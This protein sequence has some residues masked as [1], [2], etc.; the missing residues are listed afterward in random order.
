MAS[1]QSAKSTNKRSKTSQQQP[2]TKAAVTDEE[3][4]KK[5][6]IK[7]AKEL[8]K[9]EAEKKRNAEIAARIA[10]ANTRISSQIL[11]IQCDDA[12]QSK[13]QTPPQATKN[14]THQLQQND[15]IH[16]PTEL[17]HQKDN[18][19]HPLSLP[20][21]RKQSLSTAEKSSTSN[22]KQPA[23][24]KQK[25]PLAAKSSTRPSQLPQ[26]A[27]PA[28]QSELDHQEDT[29]H[30]LSLPAFRKQSPSTAEKSSTSNKKQPA[31]RKQK[32]PLAAKSS[33]HPSQLP[34][35]ASPACQSELDHQEDTIHPLSLP[36]FRNQTLSKPLPS[37]ASKTARRA[38]HRQKDDAKKTCIGDSSITS[39]VVSDD[40]EID[41]GVITISC[42]NED[43]KALLLENKSL[44]DKL[45]KLQRRL[46][47]AG[48]FINMILL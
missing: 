17:E 6:A 47:I 35:N 42:D 38:P 21:F 14:S 46:D 22:K 36:A 31:N 8:E 4:A 13:Q 3:K 16:Q 30:P 11:Q 24:R 39:L 2:S 37:T 29:I 48:K 33:T 23:N 5:E 44:R 18:S 45:K 28:C 1:N 20:A 19:I 15:S 9:V 7:K 25:T 34:Q 10:Q 32:N 43:C 40:D 41:E 27:S 26:N 12:H